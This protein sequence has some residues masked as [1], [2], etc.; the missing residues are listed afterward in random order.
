[1]RL[2]TMFGAALLSLAL[3]L[4]AVADHGSRAR[5]HDSVAHRARGDVHLYK[6]F[7]N[8]RYTFFDVGL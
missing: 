7:D 6:R 1:M 8:A 4:L 5:R 2:S 3:P